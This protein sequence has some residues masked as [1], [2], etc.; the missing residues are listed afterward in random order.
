MRIP[1]ELV[2]AT[3][4]HRI[5]PFVGAGVSVGVKP[6]LFPTWQTLMEYLAVELD[7]NQLAEEA[8]TVRQL[9]AA[10]DYLKAA[11]S[12]HKHLGPYLF[13]GELRRRFKQRRPSDGDFAVARGIWA[14]EPSMVI[15]TNYD[16]VLR[17]AGP[18]DVQAVT[19]DQEEE[20]ALLSGAS[21]E[22]PWLWHLHGTIQRL[23]TLILAGTDYRLLYGPESE[24]AKQYMRAVFEL[25][26][27]LASRPFLYVG[28]S[29][30]DP[31]VVQ[32]IEDVLKL[33]KGNSAPSYALMKKGEGAVAALR[34]N[35][36]IH[37]VEYEDHGAPLAALLEELAAKAFGSSPLAMS[38][39]VADP[40]SQGRSSVALFSATEASPPIEPAPASM[41]GKA[42]FVPRPGL[43]DEYAQ[44]LARSRCL[45]ILA[46]RRGGAR[47]LT[48]RIAAERFANRVTWLTPP[49]VPRCEIGE[50]LASLTE[51]PS[52]NSFPALTAWIRESASQLGGNH[53]IGLR[54][55]GGPIDHLRTLCDE[56]RKLTEDRNANF[57]VVVPGG[58]SS[59]WLRFNTPDASLFSGAPARHVPSLS[60]E[61]VRAVLD[62]ARAD[63]G[64]GAE[65]V[66]RATGG[67]PGLLEE[68]I[69]SCGSGT[70]FDEMTARLAESPTLHAVL[71]MRFAADD[72]AGHPAQRH[73][74]TTLRDLIA[75]RPVKN[76]NDIEDEL[77]YP[78]V[79][80]Y[81]DGL[82]I[83][84]DETGGKT[85]LRCEAVRLVVERTLALEDD[86]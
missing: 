44:E 2:R 7:G 75:G 53:L 84:G 42:A 34:S 51:Q 86:A 71:R 49:V 77:R 54:H 39:A 30:N 20:L 63:G 4:A 56:L 13:N 70:P 26:S 35:C 60:I 47:A 64:R 72:R 16:D 19:N 6:G 5:V 45:L 85:E 12:A 83:G 27:M 55:D 10:K 3:R 8:K 73:A 81:Y 9:I 23:G 48:R 52:L 36:N 79:R 32:Q 82:V 78:E 80:L 62:N 18:P 65:D 38:R 50:Y 58:A 28:F 57:F 61:E 33:T 29:L 22:W 41:S 31:Y 21:H 14:L 11:E 59:A 68:V 76:L 67:H 24:R 25:H 17:W 40:V 43:E 37:V 66:H 74:R 46:P 1:S 15:T 69:L